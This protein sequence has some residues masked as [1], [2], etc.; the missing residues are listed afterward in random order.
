MKLL[1]RSILAALI[2]LSSLA[3]VADTSSPN[4][5]QSSS[6]APITLPDEPAPQ[7][8]GARA[9]APTKAPTLS[10]ADAANIVR[11]QTG[12]QVMAVQPRQMSGRTFYAVKVLSNGRMRTI[13]VDGDT[14]RT[15]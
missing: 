7:G 12:G 3:S 5:A 11:T 10:Q 6:S 9:V 13:M 4:N 8:N 2:G 14:G 15:R 1:F